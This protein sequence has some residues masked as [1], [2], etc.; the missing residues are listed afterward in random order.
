MLPK[1]LHLHLNTALLQKLY[2]EIEAPKMRAFC[3]GEFFFLLLAAAH[4]IKA[5]L[6]SSIKAAKLAVRGVQ[7]QISRSFAKCTQ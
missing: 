2:T 4:W 3:V 6:R 1:I 5:E 7:F